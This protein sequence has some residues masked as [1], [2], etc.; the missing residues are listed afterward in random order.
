[1]GPGSTM[2]YLTKISPAIPCLRVVQQHMEKQF[3]TVTRGTQHGKPDKEADIAKLTEEYIQS[4]LYLHKPGR[5]IKLN[6]NRA[7]DV[8]TG[9]AINLGKET[10]LDNWFCR[11]SHK[12]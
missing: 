4:E 6:D 10:T 3:K 2:E 5:K 12:C 7:T 8:T 1:M 9:G 11:C